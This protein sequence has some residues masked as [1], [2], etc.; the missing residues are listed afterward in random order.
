MS[1]LCFF[2]SFLANFNC[3]SDKS[4]PVRIAPLLESAIEH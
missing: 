3:S 2:A 4:I 1:T